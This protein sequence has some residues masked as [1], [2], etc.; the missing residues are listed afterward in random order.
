MALTF[1][2][3]AAEIN[4]MTEE[5]QNSTVTVHV[6]GV[7]EFYAVVDDCPLC[8]VDESKEDTLDNGHP[9]LVI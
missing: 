5:Q 9:Y 3:L 8:F 6:S 7:G 1:K 2:Q 4:S